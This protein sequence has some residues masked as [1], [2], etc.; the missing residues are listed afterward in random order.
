MAAASPSASPAHAATPTDSANLMMIGLYIRF[1][2][3]HAW[4]CALDELV[5]EPQRSNEQILEAVQMA[6]IVEMD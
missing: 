3:L 4:T 1:T 6:W 2:D 5:D